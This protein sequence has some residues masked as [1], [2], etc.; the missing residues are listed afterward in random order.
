MLRSEVIDSDKASSRSCLEFANTLLWHASEHPEETLHSYADLVTWAQRARLVSNH[1]A[2]KLLDGA[3]D[4]PAE[5]SRVLKR[6]TALRETIYRIFA[7]LSHER[8]PAEADLAA[9]NKT[10]TRM[11]NGAHIVKTAKGFAWNWDVDEDALDSLIWP[12][13]LSAAEVLISDERERVGQCADDRGCGW[14]FLDNSKNR[15]RRWCDINDCGN[16]AKQRRHYQRTRR[17][18]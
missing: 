5:A 10:L 16:R 17:H 6:A 9:L 8:S 15:S 11:S 7:S 14:L 2:Q 12:I 18:A 1:A 13:V 3:A 4:R